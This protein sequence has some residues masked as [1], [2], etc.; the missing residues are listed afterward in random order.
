MAAFFALAVVAGC[1]SQQVVDPTPITI[2]NLDRVHV[3]SAA[4]DVLTRM[5]FTI[6]KSEIDAGYL[7]TRPLRGGQWFELWRSDNASA[8]QSAQSNLHSLQ[9]TAE[10]HV[11]E[12]AGG[13]QVDCTVSIRR[14][15]LPENDRVTMSRA[16]AMFTDS[17]AALQRLRINPGQAR[18]MEWI[19]M[20]PDEALAARILDHI[21]RHIAAQG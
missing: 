3:I 11:S 8:Y 10:V 21:R 19:D 15:S 5:H 2:T 16:A 18:G 20:G 4:E 6:E 12:I 17:S 7:K 14:L 1:S 9:R 13:V